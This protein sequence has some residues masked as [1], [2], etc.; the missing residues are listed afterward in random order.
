MSSVPAIR[1]ERPG[2]AP[3]VRAMLEAAFGG[4]AEADLVDKLRADGDLVLSLVAEHGGVAGY[5]AFP[6]LTLDLGERSVPVVGL[7]P[8]TV[9]PDRQRQ[10]TGSALIRAGLARMK[11]RGERLVFVLGEP[12]CYGRFGFE[13]MPGFASPYAGPYF[14]ALKLAPDAPLSGTVSYPKPFAELG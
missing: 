13:V 8:V 7:A 10:G 14:Q 3:Q 9:A 6:R 4:A 1:L 2:D 11:D 12:A 5:V